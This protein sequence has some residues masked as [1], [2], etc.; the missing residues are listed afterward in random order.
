MLTHALEAVLGMLSFA[1]LPLP[2]FSDACS[3]GYMSG[4][5][6]ARNVLKLQIGF[7]TLTTGSKIW[8]LLIEMAYEYTGEMYFRLYFYLF[9]EKMI[10]SIFLKLKGYLRKECFFL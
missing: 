5:M 1:N 7:I 3:Y 8:L 10:T 4:C 2:T 9:V 6:C